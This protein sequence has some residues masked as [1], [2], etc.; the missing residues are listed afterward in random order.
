MIVS[1]FRGFFSFP[2]ITHC[3]SASELVRMMIISAGDLQN[4]MFFLCF[5]CSSAEK[6]CMDSMA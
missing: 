1:F 5:I 3:S 2:F 6:I 4:V